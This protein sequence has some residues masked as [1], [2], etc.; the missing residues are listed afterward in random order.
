MVSAKIFAVM[1]ALFFATSALAQERI[2]APAV[3]KQQQ[4]VM[5]ETAQ[6]MISLNNTDVALAEAPAVFNKKIESIVALG[7]E[8]GVENPKIQSYNYN[9]YNNSGGGCCEGDCGD[10]APGH[11]RYNGSVTFNVEPVAKAAGFADLLSKNGYSA[12]LNVNAYSQCQ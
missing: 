10:G 7:K 11:Y 5:T 9:V 1:L 8:A 6:V 2:E 4:C 3:S 12:N